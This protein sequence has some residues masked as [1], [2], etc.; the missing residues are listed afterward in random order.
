MPCRS[1]RDRT[2]SV[3][4]L[5]AS[6]LLAAVAGAEA[7]AIS[8]TLR[9]VSAS[10]QRPVAKRANPYPGRAN[11]IPVAAPPRG[12]VQDA[13]VYLELTPAEAAK[14]PPPAGE[15]PHLEQRGQTFVPRV[16]AV[17]RGATVDFPNQ[18]PI[19]HNVF[20]F[21]PAKRFDLGKYPQGQSRPVRFDTPGLVNV[22]CDIHSDMEAFVLVLPHAGFARPTASGAFALPALPAGR[23]VVKAWHPDLGERARTIEVPEA[24]DVAVDLEL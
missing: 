3:V 24:G 14:L 10:A 1:L 12:R 2:R 21:S 16:L 22:Y 4:L 20:S 18:D 11:A 5:V 6:G 15:R 8:G 13:V 19:Y 7:G 9:L 17:A 23:Y